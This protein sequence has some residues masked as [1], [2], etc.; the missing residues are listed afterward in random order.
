MTERPKWPEE[1]TPRPRHVDRG[2]STGEIDDEEELTGFVK[3]KEASDL[4]ERYARGLDKNPAVDGYIYSYYVETPFQ[5]PGQSNE[6]DFIVFAFGQKWP[7]EIDAEFTHKTVAQKANNRRRDQL[8]S[9]ILRRY[10]YQPIE[11]IPGDPWL[12]SQERADA[13]TRDQF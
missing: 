13:L 10:G 5:I 3:G 4:E 8:L 11:R 1:S 2:P 12:Q 9:G 7:K 6:I